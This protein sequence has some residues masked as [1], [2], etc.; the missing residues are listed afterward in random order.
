VLN[1]S[2]SSRAYGLRLWS[3]RLGGCHDVIDGFR[4]V[5]YRLGRWCDV[6]WRTQKEG[7]HQ[8]GPTRSC[9]AK[10][11]V[12]D[13]WIVLPDQTMRSSPQHCRC[14]RL[15][16]EM[17]KRYQII[18]DAGRGQTHVSVVPPRR[19]YPNRADSTFL[20]FHLP[21]LSS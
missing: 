17:G 1:S 3:P 12:V 7:P 5:A 8:V 6:A 21:P 13:G 2:S 11:V 4:L 10:A 16:R 15:V 9:V 20:P 18:Q 19:C 14:R